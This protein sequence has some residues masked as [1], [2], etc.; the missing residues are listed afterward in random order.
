LKLIN[1]FFKNMYLKFRNIAISGGVAVGKNTLLD[2]LK[3]YLKPHGWRFTSGG[4][5][6]RDFTKEYI[7]PLA[8]LVPDDFHNKLDKRT[9]DL[10][11]D[12]KY[13]IEAWLAGFM[14]RE[15][16]DTL[17]VLLMCGNDALR[18]DRVVNRD[19]IS[20]NEAKEFI[21]D[22]EEGNFVEW[23]RIYGNYNFFDPKYYHLV[24]DTYSSGPHETVGIVLDLL[25]YKNGKDEKS[26][27]KE[28]HL[29]K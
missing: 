9:T 21:K 11:E 19:R 17:R 25:G 15:R 12:G 1:I 20:I 4:R 28:K 6:L 22:R 16:N 13:V 8:K 5:I 27:T 10:M 2:N 3:P 18:I 7:Q 26:L 14:T 29:V 23:K 24:I